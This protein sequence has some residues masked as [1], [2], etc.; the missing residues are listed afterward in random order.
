L[1]F[2]PA[3]WVKVLEGLTVEFIPVTNGAAKA[4]AVDVVKR[5]VVR[6]IELGIVNFKLDIWGNPDVP[7][8]LIP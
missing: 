3:A 5:C 8:R 1:N 6:P 4:A 2:H 7:V